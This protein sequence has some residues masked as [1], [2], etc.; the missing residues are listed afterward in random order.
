MK[1][2]QRKA[3][4]ALSYVSMMLGYIISL[5]YT[6]FMI[7][8]LGQSDYGLYN[9]VASVVAYLGVL[10]FGF[11]SAYMRYYIRIKEM[12]DRENI[13]KL[14][15]MFLTIFSVIALL[16]V[17]AGVVLSFHAETVFGSKLTAGELA[18]AKILML[19]LSFNMA[20]SFPASVFTSHITAN[21]RF[22]FQRIVQMIKLVTNP[23]LVLPALLLGYGSVG[24]AL[25]T[26]SINLGVEIAHM[27]YC[28][29]KLRMRF[30]LR[31]FDHRLMREVT[32]FS[33]YIFINILVNQVNW[34]VDKF[35]LGRY[36]GTATVAVYG[37]AAQ[38]NTYFMGISTTISNVF[39]PRVHKIV[40]AGDDAKSL[41]SLFTRI[42]RL[43]FFILSLIASGL[44]FFGRPF[45]SLW[46]GPGYADSYPIA[47]L[48][49]LPVTIPLIQNIGIEIQAAKN[50]HRFRSIAYLLIAVFNVALTLVLARR[51]FG[52][53]AALGTAVA[54]LLGNGLAMNWYYHKKVGIDII[55]F[56]KEIAR[57]LPAFLPPVALGILLSLYGGLYRPL[58]FLLWGLLYILVFCACMWRWGMNQYEKDLFI[59]P[60]RRIAKRI[61]GS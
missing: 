11:G 22:V 25:V 28:R 12:D 26:T 4:A 7:R 21:E 50:M 6:P 56:W 36:H 58:N 49:I 54:L 35:I 41:T 38:L 24:M 43:Q 60:F 46:A 17:S 29:R 39:I 1:Y 42:G 53:G 15:G 27:V 10:N 30:T 19:I 44:V 34:N 31:G 14:N 37:L 23:F 40:A 57:I 47:L 52:A 16:A 45:F 51:Y 13:A 61:R 8:L 5:A 32:A 20:F 18:R 48:L 3:G 9:L 2:N 59:K 55:H 33:S